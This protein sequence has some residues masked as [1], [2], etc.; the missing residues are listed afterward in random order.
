IASWNLTDSGSFSSNGAALRPVKV[1]ATSA[2]TCCT[3][4][5]SEKLGK[6]KA[7]KVTPACLD[8][9]YTAMATLL[10]MA[11]AAASMPLDFMACA[12][13]VKSPGTKGTLKREYPTPRPTCAASLAKIWPAAVACGSA[14]VKL[15][16]LVAP[17]F[18]MNWGSAV[19]PVPGMTA[20]LMLKK[21]LCLAPTSVVD[22]PTSGTPCAWK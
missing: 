7:L 5:G 21:L 6:T 4:T 17:W 22:Q 10:V 16:A 19:L 8:E 14:T 3:A 15:A 9:L 12:S 2:P 11:S 18:F 20:P 13:A 1:P